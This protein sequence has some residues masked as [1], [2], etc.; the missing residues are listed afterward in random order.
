MKKLSYLSVAAAAL[1]LGACS[2][3]DILDGAA[4]EGA[5]SSTSA[6]TRGGYINVG[7]NLPTTPATA[8][9]DPNGGVF[10]DGSANEYAVKDAV[11]VIFEKAA[12][13][14]ESSAT[15]RAAYDLLNL[16][17]WEN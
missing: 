10:A 9:D 1:L 13:A 8:K 11:L 2:S 16:K 4:G 14:P 15:C 12:D 5:G 17:P 6:V 3:D 7:I